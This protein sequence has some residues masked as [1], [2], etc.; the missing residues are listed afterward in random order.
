MSRPR[1]PPQFILDEETAEDSSSQSATESL[2]PYSPTP[3]S[4]SYPPEPSEKPPERDPDS[5]SISD[6]DDD[7]LSPPPP[8][9]YSITIPSKEAVYLSKQHPPKRK[10]HTKLVLLGLIS[11]L[12]FAWGATQFLTMFTRFNGSPKVQVILMISDG[13]GPASETF[14]RSYLEYLHTTNSTTIYKGDERRSLL[15][16]SVWAGFEK[17]FA[18]DNGGSGSPLDSIL[19]GSSRTR[20]SNSLITDS[21]AG[22]TAFSCLLKTYNG[23][24]GVNPSRTPCGTILE[25]SHRQGFSTGIV[26]TSRITHATPA[27]FYS[28][29]PDRDLESQIAKDLV[30]GSDGQGR[31]VD[32]AFGGGK[33]FFVGKN[34]STGGTTSCRDD[35]EDLLGSQA[36]EGIRVVEGMKGLRE[37]KDEEMEGRG[38]KKKKGDMVLGLFANDHM[39]YEIDRQGTEHLVDEQPSLKEMTT[40]AL[41]YLQKHGSSGKGF[42]LLIEGARIDMAAHN[43]DPI[44]HLSDILAYYETVQLVKEWVDRQNE[45]EGVPTV[46]ISVSDHETGGL[47]LGRQLDK[48]VY[49][50]Y[51]WY[52]E[53]LNN[54]TRSTSYLGKEIADRYPMTTRDWIES[55]VFVKGLGIRD[56]GKWEMDQV[57][58]NRSD[59]YKASRV[60]ADSVSRRAQVGWSTAGHSGVDVNLYAY[61]HNSTGLKGCVEN[62]HVGEFVAHTMGLNLDVVT[63]ELNKDLKSWYDPN[64]GHSEA[65]THGLKHYEGEF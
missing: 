47:T 15:N 60:L 23:A 58:M 17:E 51:L 11:L 62:V 45:R 9:S 31:T 64:A 29:V 32:F 42:F 36:M 53:V 46:L 14:A 38:G 39:D 21:A 25:A 43:N 19:V 10:R 48:E 8:N 56:V 12:G 4:H 55:E 40:H 28:H 50:E 2:L 13:M 16:E 1:T 49:P 18:W 35:G 26:T 5:L 22:A 20:S 6:A 37:W 44:S 65:R 63:L 41:R 33:C 57:W 24:I 52:P 34:S 3:A 7:A 59:A 30:K 54:A 27:S 61:G